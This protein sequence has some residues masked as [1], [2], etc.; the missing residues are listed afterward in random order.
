MCRCPFV[1]LL[2]YFIEVY[3]LLRCMICV[4]LRLLKFIYEWCWILLFSRDVASISWIFVIF[5]CFIALIEIG[6][7]KLVSEPWSV[8]SRLTTSIRDFS[9][10]YA[11]GSGLPSVLVLLCCC[12]YLLVGLALCSLEMAGGWWVIDSLIYCLI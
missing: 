12:S 3:S 1:I 11:N 8:L 6:C 5:A 10:L 9:C 2:D 4:P 7:Y